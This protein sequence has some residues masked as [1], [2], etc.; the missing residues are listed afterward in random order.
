MCTAVKHVHLY[1]QENMAI[2][3]GSRAHLEQESVAQVIICV[4]VKRAKYCC[5][6]PSDI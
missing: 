4:D 5:L 2:S 3:C 1:I 6:R